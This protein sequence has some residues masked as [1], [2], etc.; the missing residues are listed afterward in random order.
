MFFSLSL[1]VL[2]LS[3]FLF[4]HSCVSL[5]SC[6]CVSFS[7]LSLNS[8]SN[9]RS[10]VSVKGKSLLGKGIAHQGHQDGAERE[11]PFVDGRRG[12]SVVVVGGRCCPSRTPRSGRA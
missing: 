7:F 12:S 4:F 6:L 8:T 9:S 1:S 5:F 11:R 10:L 3:S 2:F